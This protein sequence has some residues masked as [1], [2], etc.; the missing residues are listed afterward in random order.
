MLKTRLEKFYEKVVCEDFVLLYNLKNLYTLPVFEKAILN[1]TSKNFVSEKEALL[2]QFSAFFLQTGKLPIN[3]R[4]HNS[5]ALFNIRQGSILGLKTTLRNQSLYNYL[6]KTL[7]FVI[8]KTI[9]TLGLEKPTKNKS[10]LFSPEK[11]PSIGVENASSPFTIGDVMRSIDSDT[12]LVENALSLTKEN[13]ST[14]LKNQNK[15]IFTKNNRFK[16]EIIKHDTLS[17]T[18]EDYVSQLKKKR[19]FVIS[20]NKVTRFPEISSLLLFFNS[21]TGFSLDFSLTLYGQK[22]LSKLTA[23]SKQGSTNK[24]KS[25]DCNKSSR[26]ISAFGYPLFL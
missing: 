23:S 7:I 25:I 19:D 26:F 12:T 21:T 22:G 18:V 10:T 1:T 16:Q 2:Q 4:A 17:T 24:K 14:K 5:I 8:P 9:S 20:E 15:K 3:T 6:D 11:E 13:V